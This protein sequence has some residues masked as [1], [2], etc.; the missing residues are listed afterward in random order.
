MSNFRGALQNTIGEFV[1]SGCRSLKEVVIEDGNSE[2]A[3][4]S[5][6]SNQLFNNCPLQTVYIGRN[7]NYNT[8]SSC[9]YSPFYRCTTLRSVTITDKETEISPNEFYGCTNLKNVN[10]G[11]GVTKIGDWAFSGCFSLDYFSFGSAMQ[12]IGKEAFSDCTAMTRIISHAAT[13]PVCG[14][15]ALDDINKWNC[16]LSVPTGYTAAYQAADQWKEFFF[17]NDD[18]TITDIGSVQDSTAK[19]SS[20]YNL[21]GSQQRDMMPGLNIIKM[22]DGTIRKVI[23]K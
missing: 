15:Q 22:S 5:N 2:L 8:S 23:V 20:I 17:I 7:I 6:R 1:F 12:S 4:G 16:T 9:G 18:V 13:P 3:L 19:P 10:I 11:N 21:N 14:S